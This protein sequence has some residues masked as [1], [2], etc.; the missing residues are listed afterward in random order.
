MA[1]KK[2]TYVCPICKEEQDRAVQ[3]QT[4]S[5][6][7]EYDFGNNQICPDEIDKTGGDHECWCCPDCS[8]D[9]LPEE[10]CEKIEKHLGWR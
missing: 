7:W 8:P 10:I 4:M 2:F 3:W 9:G 5:V 1:K 6:A